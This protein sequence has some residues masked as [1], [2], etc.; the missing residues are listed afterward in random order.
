MP[1]LASH[2]RIASPLRLAA[3]VASLLFAANVFAAPRI[4]D[5]SLRG[6]QLGAT[7]TVTLSGAEL[8]PEPQLLLG[9]EPLPIAIKEGSTAE[10]IELEIALPADNFPGIRQL[11]LANPLGISN[12]VAVVVDEL[13]QSSAKSE[14]TTW[15]V[16]ISGR[17]EGS[18]RVVTPIDGAAGKTLT[19]EVEARRLGSNL[20]PVV[21]ILNAS[22]V[23]LAWAQADSQL[24]GDV[25]LSV[26]LPTDG[27]Y[28]I[29]LHDA[30]FQGQP[31]AFFRMKVTE[32]SAPSAPFL[33]GVNADDLRARALTSLV[34][35]RFDPNSWRPVRSERPSIAPTGL[36]RLFVSS[37]REVV[38]EDDSRLSGML[39]APVGINGR[40]R[41]SG[42]EDSYRIAAAPGTKLKIECWAERANS[43]LDGV[44]TIRDQQGNQLAT[45]DDQAGT[46][47]PGLEF[48]VPA[49]AGPIVLAL[50]DLRHRGGEDFRYRLSVT[51][52]DAPEARVTL[53]ADRFLIPRGGATIVRAHADRQAFAG[54]IAV[55]FAGL[56]SGITVENAEIPAGASDA[57]LAIRCADEGTAGVV[58]VFAETVGLP[59]PVSC[60]VQ[61]PLN[62]V[63]QFSPWLASEFAL[64][65]TPPA[66]LTV[67]WDAPSENDALTLAGTTSFTASV[68]RASGVMGPVR[69][70]L[71]TSQIAP[72]KS[73]N[74]QT[75]PDV[76]RTLRLAQDVVVPAD[77]SAI[78]LPVVVPADLAEFPHDLALKADLLSADG[79]QVV[80][81]AY[82]ASRRLIVR[83]PSFEL[84]LAGAA[85]L[86]PSADGQLT[87]ELR[88][89][90]N[91]SPG[92][93]RAVTVK[94]AG[95]P[96][97]QTVI[98]PE[99]QNDFS[100]TATLP[101]AIPLAE[102]RHLKLTATS[103]LA[104][105]NVINASNEVPLTLQ[106]S[107]GE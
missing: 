24:D 53:D 55:R 28:Q 39:A 62:S 52:A 105:Q 100:L 35:D 95:L 31:P 104:P 67:A 98:V 63:T 72:T 37:W 85:N 16:A 45:A 92:F 1:L 11:R 102:L 51:P 60:L 106:F 80:A 89:S 49:N 21:H 2:R 15:P 13:S 25:R 34:G 3:C 94:L 86:I 78:Q 9:E 91:R 18:T 59:E 22:G 36:L 96:T 93:S 56:P 26:A 88:G 23:Q 30:L 81:T 66:P 40:L 43:P 75:V 84:K 65:A 61:G 77:Q 73:E 33:R 57:L 29:E 5:I 20:K 68:A 7:T 12:A 19:V 14:P 27:R 107:A 42:E 83:K 87:V 58:Q 47:D 4:D 74:N 101:A 64:A 41:S 17:C 44:L 70:S 8:L 54:P 10:R 46:V 50:H 90:V 76:E 32:E 71:L 79:S 38:E 99:G 48:E 103:E 6:L 97:E 82:A 69:L